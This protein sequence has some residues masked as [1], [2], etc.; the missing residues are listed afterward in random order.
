MAV[1]VLRQCQPGQLQSGAFGASISLH[2]ASKQGML[3]PSALQSASVSQSA[4]FPSLDLQDGKLL[5]KNHTFDD[6]AAAAE[7]LIKVCACVAVAVPGSELPT[8]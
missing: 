7:F 4:L 8:S 3:P 2:A 5:A 6:V 1:P